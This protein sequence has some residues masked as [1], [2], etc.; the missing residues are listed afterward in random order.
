MNKLSWL[1]IFSNLISAI[2]VFLGLAYVL[3]RA[4]DFPL[5][6]KMAY[7]SAASPVPQVFDEINGYEYW[8]G[9]YKIIYE[10]ERRVEKTLEIQYKNLQQLP[11]PHLLKIMYLLPFSLGPIASQK[12]W[13]PSLVDGYCKRDFLRLNASKI[14]IVAQSRKNGK[15]LEWSEGISCDRP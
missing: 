12:M 15:P 8:A 6:Q 3:G 14:K 10:D 13:M 9:S 2:L 5:I 1:N 11:S 7:I 4:F